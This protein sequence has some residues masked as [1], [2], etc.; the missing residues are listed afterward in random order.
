MGDVNRAAILAFIQ[1]IF[2]VLQFSGA[3]SFSGDE[4]AAIMLL[5][6]N[7]LPLIFLVVKAGQSSSSTLT[8]SV[9]APTGGGASMN[10]PE[11]PGPNAH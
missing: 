5:V 3:V 10:A 11:P 1:S 6:G 8:A 2:P 9:T 7:A 4:V